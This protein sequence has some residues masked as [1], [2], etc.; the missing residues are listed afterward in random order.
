MLSFIW[1]CCNHS[2]PLSLLPLAPLCKLG[3][4][5]DPE[6][7]LCTFSPPLCGPMG[8]FDKQTT[9]FSYLCC[10]SVVLRIVISW[11]LFGVFGRV[12][13]V[14]VLFYF[15]SQPPPHF[16]AQFREWGKQKVILFLSMS[17]ITQYTRRGQIHY[18]ARKNMLGGGRG[19]TG[20]LSMF[21]FSNQIIK[22]H[23]HTTCPLHHTILILFKVEGGGWGK[24]FTLSLSHESDLLFYFYSQSLPQHLIMRIVF[25]KL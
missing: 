7:L 8:S 21:L 15:C 1:D 14:F 16:P 18:P 23:T 19:E 24:Y 11:Y 13:S 22:L 9:F 4:S 10:V 3:E 2:T 20:V 17:I 25:L 6:G 5:V 12:G